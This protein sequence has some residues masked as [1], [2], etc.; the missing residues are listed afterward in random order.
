MLKWPGGDYQWS[1]IISEERC[2][3]FSE[4]VSSRPVNVTMFK[5]LYSLLETTVYAISQIRGSENV[6]KLENIFF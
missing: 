4:Y 6:P 5:P 3:V 2:R 1:I